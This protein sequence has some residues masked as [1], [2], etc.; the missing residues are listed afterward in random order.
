MLGSVAL[1]IFTVATKIPS[2]INVMIS[3]FQQSWGISSVKEI[4]SSNDSE[5]Y[6]NVFNTFSFIAFA[7]GIGLTFI[8]KPLMTVYV[9]SDFVEAWRYI[10]LL[11]ASA[12][13]S[14]I[15][16]YFVTMYSALKKSVNNMVTT[17]I[18][19]ITNVVLSLILVYHIG[20]WGAIIG[21]FTSYFVM[22]TI[23]MIDVKRFIKIKTDTVR[24]VANSVILITETVLVSMEIQIYLVSAIA[25]L[26]FL[27]INF[28][29]LKD[30]LTNIKG[31]KA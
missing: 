14:A 23:R 3:I 26:L 7:M 31:R 24:F 29:F 22:A 17:L 30:L 10:P 8:I 13:F 19:A 6:S 18:G 27:I 16:S 2:L 12:T 28:K 25:I 20:L 9:G 1:G 4:E 15:S 11:L 21:T 5:F